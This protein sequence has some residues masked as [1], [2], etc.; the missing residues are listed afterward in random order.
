MTEKV[1]LDATCSSRMMWFNKQHPAALYVDKRIVH[2]EAM[3]KSGNGEATRHLNI[4]P[5]VI[6]DFTNLPF[7]D[8]SFSLVVF[9]PPPSHENQRNSLAGEKVWQTR[10]RLETNFA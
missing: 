9:D 10:P 1:I 7:K 8:N 4:E 5:D 6:A 2:D 3:W